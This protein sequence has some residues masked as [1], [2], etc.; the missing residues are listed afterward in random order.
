MLTS[1]TVWPQE[2]VLPFQPPAWLKL[3]ALQKG[4]K[5]LRLSEKRPQL[6]E[7]PPRLSEKQPGTKKLPGCEQLKEMP[8]KPATESHLDLKRFCEPRSQGHRRA[9]RRSASQ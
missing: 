3:L 7:K 6:S 9:R 1:T 8:V 4:K 2:K 5:R